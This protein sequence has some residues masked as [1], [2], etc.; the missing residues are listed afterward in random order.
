MKKLTPGFKKISVKQ[1]FGVDTDETFMYSAPDRVSNIEVSD[2][3]YVFN[4]IFVKKL[5]MWYGATAP[6]KNLLITGNS[7][8]GKTAVV[9]EFIYRLN[10]DVYAISGSGKLR[11]EDLV[12]TMVINK[13]GETVFVDGPLTRAMREGAVFL[14]NELTRM[15]A[16]EQMRLVDVLDERSSLVITQTGEVI[17]PHPNFRFAATGNSTGLGDEL[18]IYAGE[19]RGSAAFFQRFLKLKVNELTKEQE[20]GYLMKKA[21]QLG[22]AIIDKMLDFA[23]EIRDVFNNGNI[24]TSNI[25]TRSVSAWATLSVSYHQFIEYT[26]KHATI[27]PVSA[28][29]EDVILN[30]IPSDEAATFKEIYTKY[31]GK[32]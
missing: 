3:D 8:I 18:G 7:G 32:S 2:P 9:L 25:P 11:F 20:K 10:G 6:N 29:L 1:A 17:T 4:K 30:G 14:I 21:P 24:I 15:D 16:G 26:D 13:Q 28:A 12:G 5:F 27:D 23:H 19:K 31:F 22:S